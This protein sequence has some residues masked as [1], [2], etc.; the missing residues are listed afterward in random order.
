MI[1][2]AQP[3]T[4]ASDHPL[5]VVSFTGDS[6]IADY[7]V[8]LARELA[9]IAPTTFLTSNRL[10]APFEGLGFEVVKIFR[11]TRWYPLDI[12]RFAWWCL[13]HRPRAV[14]LQSVLKLPLVDGLVVALLR[15]AGMRCV[16]TVHDVMPHD[17]RPWSRREYAW[18]YRRFDG[19]VVHSEAARAQVGR[20]APGVAVLKVPHGVYDVFR[21][22]VP[23]RAA[24]RGR[25]GLTRSGAGP[26][27]VLF[28]GH[29]EA[30]KG[31]GVVV[32]V[33][34]RLRDHPEFHFVIAGAPPG[35]HRPPAL[36]L[37]LERARALPNVFV[38][39]ARVPFE[40]VQD[41]FAAAD[42]VALPYLEGSTSGVLK[43]AIAFGV[44]VVATRVGDLVEEVPPEGG[45]L[46]ERDGALQ[47]R[48]LAAIL[49]AQQRHHALREGMR[50]AAGAREWADIAARYHR[51][52]T[53]AWGP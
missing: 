6:G 48:F 26:F 50:A 29:L 41:Y 1:R 21:L 23:T 20:L 32:G 12:V 22:D 24:A 7:S 28:F 10:P 2:A 53:A 3:S 40:C 30:R 13:S 35:S 42:L 49:E 33:A 4:P 34:E 31:L 8:S 37:A 14:S 15:A 9:R 27:V 45:I 19:L 17:P 5:V 38:H 43:L 16:L 52:L 51:F 47:E 36:L 44:P 39:D 25:I 18:F 11:R 46:V